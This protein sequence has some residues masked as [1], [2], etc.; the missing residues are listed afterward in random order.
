MLNAVEALIR[1]RGLIPPGSFVLCAVSGGADSVCLLHILYRLRERVPFSLAA[2]HYNHRLRGEESERDAAFVSEFVSRYCPG[3]PL[4]TGSGDVRGESARRGTGLE[5]TARELRYA[6]L[7][8]TAKAAGADRIATAH[9]AGDNAETVLLNL[10]RGTGL[11]GLSGI[12]IVQGAVIRPLL[13]SSRGEITAYLRENGLPHVEDSSN[14]D[15]IY[16]RNKLRRQVMPLLRE[17]NPR[18][19]EHINAAA[20]Q[21]SEADS[22]LDR[23]ARRAFVGLGTGPDWVS[24]PWDRLDMAPAP[25][26]PRLLLLLLDQME[27]GRKDFGTVH[28]EAVLQLENGRSL[29]LPRGVTARREGGRLF[30]AR[31]QAP[32]DQAPLERGKPLA[33]GGYL[34]TLLD[35]PEGAGLALSVPAGAVLTVGPCPPAQWLTLPGSGGA[36]MVKRLCL[37]R[38]IGL[39]E[40]DGLPAFYADGRLAAVWPLGADAAF[41]PRQGSGRF[42]QVKKIEKDEES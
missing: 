5:E 21:V 17:L 6:F 26:R 31:R 13:A 3:I 1:A 4:H 22:Y 33:W 29:D 34:L 14:A 12:P 11:K 7:R 36:R 27:V 28:L 41:A 38:H 20:A 8:K 19:A 23:E 25:L 40:R 15:E 30:L 2:A 37:D 18:A 24:L 16:T 32:P 39:A 9:S 35:E 42:I 10:V